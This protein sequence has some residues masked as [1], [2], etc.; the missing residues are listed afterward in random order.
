VGE[1]LRQ[2]GI[3]GPLLWV[4]LVGFLIM[5]AILKTL[6][7]DRVRRFMAAREAEEERRRHE[8]AHAEKDLESAEAAMRARAA[9]IE[10]Q[11]YER[12]QAEVRA[13][14]A[15]KGELLEEAHGHARADLARV[16][17]SL[18]SDRTA[19]LAHLGDDVR[20]LALF[21]AQDALGKK[22]DG[23]KYAATA[24]KAVAGA[25]PGRPS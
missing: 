8:L 19:A 22:V 3:R 17:A 5:F 2:I 6:L 21:V 9:E 25:L 12:V 24:A 23:A 16:R 11:A 13:G 1:I 20:E 4:Q 14:I 15:R 7:F 10:K 18:G